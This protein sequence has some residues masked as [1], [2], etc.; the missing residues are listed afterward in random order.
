MKIVDLTMTIKTKA[1]VHPIYVEPVVTTWTTIKETGFYSTLLIL[2]DHTLTHLDAPA[3]VIENGVTVDMLPLE[4]FIGPGIA[5]D[6]S[7]LPPRSTITRET[8]LRE[9][10][11]TGITSFEG[12][13]LLIR[14]GYDSKIGTPEWF[15]HPGLDES[16][17]KL[18]IEK[19]FKA[20][21]TDAP[22]IDREPYPAHKLLLQNNIIV[23]ENLTNLKEL[24]GR[25]FY[26]YGL[27]LK[28]YRG[29]GSLVRAIA[30]IE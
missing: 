30:I 19:K 15:D 9:L 21:G 22:S 13:V 8:L 27:P 2:N 20:V 28:I 23:Y 5:V 11:K 14:T 17:A 26:F 1:P 18:L 12:W 25:K 6:L 10:E 24:I 7:Y 16:A 29:S 3:H 4:M